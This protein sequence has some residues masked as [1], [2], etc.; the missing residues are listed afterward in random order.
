MFEK[1]TWGLY[2]TANSFVLTPLTED[3]PMKSLTIDKK[4]K[5]TTEHSYTNAKD[6]LLISEQSI[7]G[8]L[9]ILNIFQSYHLVVVKASTEV[10]RIKTSLSASSD[11]KPAIIFELNTVALIPL[12]SYEYK[13]KKLVEDIKEKIS[14]YLGMGFYFGINF[15][16]TTSAQRR[17]YREQSHF[18]PKQLIVCS[19]ETVDTRFMWNFNL[20]KDFHIQ[21]IPHY[22]C[23]PLI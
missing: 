14:K 15:D 8:L 11:V 20:C 9:D 1:P 18:D 5:K 2:E 23:V 13:D 10:C 22:W 7:Y 12:Q 3:L 21:K 6:L 17:A 4:T 19:N 16:P